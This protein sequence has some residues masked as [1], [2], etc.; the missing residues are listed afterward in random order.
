MA[1]LENLLSLEQAEDLAQYQQQVLETPLKE[2]QKKGST[3]YPVRLAHTR[4]GTGGK[5][6][7][8]LERNVEFNSPHQFQAGAQAAVF[9]NAPVGQ[10]VQQLPGTILSVDQ[11]KMEIQIMEEELPDWIDERHIGVDLLFDENSYREMKFAV[12]QVK[13]AA[14]NSRLE[15]IRDILLGYQKPEF[16]D[17]K[18]LSTD[19]WP[20]QHLNSSQKEAVTRMMAAKD[21]FVIHGPPG[22]G[23]TTTLVAAVQTALL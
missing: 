8:E 3:W 18:S 10:K 17:M 14:P 23:K 7:L 21:V 5:F 22:T 20:I 6:V 12:D 4:I 1:A 19:G 11:T 15:S 2:R 16:G 9:W 13:K